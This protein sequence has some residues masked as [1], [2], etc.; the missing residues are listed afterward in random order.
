[1]EAKLVHQE[2]GYADITSRK[3]AAKFVLVLLATDSEAA[4]SGLQCEVRLNRSQPDPRFAVS[5]PK[6]V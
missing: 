4:L 6:D 5:L 1:M 3:V 2:A